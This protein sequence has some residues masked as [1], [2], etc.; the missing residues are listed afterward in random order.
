VNKQDNM[1]HDLLLVKTIQGCTMKALET[2][3]IRMSKYYKYVV[4]R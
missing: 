2:M 4:S 3:K 1:L